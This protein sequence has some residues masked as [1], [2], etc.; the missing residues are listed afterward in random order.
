M[1]VDQLL[2]RLGNAQRVHHRPANARAFALDHQQPVLALFGLLAFDVQLQR[3]R[4]CWIARR[5][6]R[7]AGAGT[8]E[9]KYHQH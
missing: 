8:Q 9:D 1:A 3:Q 6:R 7:L 4:E 5:Q 2:P